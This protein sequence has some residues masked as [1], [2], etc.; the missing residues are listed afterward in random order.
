MLARLPWPYSIAFLP[1]GDLLVTQRS[2]ELKRVRKANG[3]VIPVAGGPESLGP[4]TT[5]GV[6]SYMAIALHPQFQRRTATYTSPTRSPTGRRARRSRNPTIAAQP[7]HP[8]AHANVAV[9]RARYANGALHD[10]R[11]VWVGEGWAARRR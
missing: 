4:V 8:T 1:D 2:G 7:A 3:E 10:T 6:H 11:D 9:A 5:A